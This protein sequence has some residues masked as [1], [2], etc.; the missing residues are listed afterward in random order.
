MLLAAGVHREAALLFFDWFF[1]SVFAFGPTGVHGKT[2]AFV[3]FPAGSTRLM[4][5]GIIGASSIAGALSVKGNI[6]IG[7]ISSALAG[8]LAGITTPSSASRFCQ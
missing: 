8:G 4:R 3:C 7:G 2:T 1:K 6:G 5:T